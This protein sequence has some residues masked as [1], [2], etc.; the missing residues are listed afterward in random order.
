MIGGLCAWLGAFALV[1]SIWLADA[2]M[3]VA[4]LMLVPIPLTG[5]VMWGATGRRPAS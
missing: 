1:A 5:L 2:G 4:W 3:L